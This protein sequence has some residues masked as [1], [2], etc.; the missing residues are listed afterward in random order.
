[1][2][3]KVRP[4]D[5]NAL[6]K[7]IREYMDNFPYAGTRLATCRVVLSMLGDE[8]QTPTLTDH[9]PDLTNMIPLTLEQL[10]EMDGQPVWAKVI[11]KTGIRCD[12]WCEVEIREKD[13]FAYVWWPGSE[14]EDIAKIEDYGKTWACYAYPPAHI[15]REAWVSVEDRMPK[16]NIREDGELVSS[17]ILCYCETDKTVHLVVSQKFYT[18]R[19]G[20]IVHPVFRYYDEWGDEIENV[21]HWTP[22][23]APPNRRPPEGEED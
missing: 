17:K 23:P 6:A 22:L 20:E 12:G 8:G 4:I 15:D 10:R 2:K 21:S 5:A 3:N 16:Y 14:V 7:R 13:P 19:K 1:M 11:G 9:F 18:G